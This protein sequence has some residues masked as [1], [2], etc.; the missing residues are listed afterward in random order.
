MIAMHFFGRNNIEVTLCV[1]NLC[2]L[3]DCILNLL[4]PDMMMFADETLV[5]RLSR[6]RMALSN[7][8]SASSERPKKHVLILLSVRTQCE[9]SC[10]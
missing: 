4:I 8:I 3:P 7:G 10:L 1:L 5:G 2:V 9:D 6:E